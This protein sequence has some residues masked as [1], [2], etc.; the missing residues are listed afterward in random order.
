MIKQIWMVNNEIYKIIIDGKLVSYQDRKM[1]NPIRMIPMD[2]KIK[3]QILMSRNKID[4]HLIEQFKLT[5]EEQKEYEEAVKSGENIEEKLALIC[6][7]DC[8][9][10]ASILQKEERI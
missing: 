2:G 8:M 4:P 10:N 3:R 7:K 9:K 1:P 5:K 6:K